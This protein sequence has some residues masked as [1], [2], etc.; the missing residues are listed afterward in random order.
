MRNCT[1]F[2]RLLRI[3]RRQGRLVRLIWAHILSDLLNPSESARFVINLTV[4]KLKTA[5]QMDLFNF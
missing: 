4:F 1:M 5:S 2:G 3:Y